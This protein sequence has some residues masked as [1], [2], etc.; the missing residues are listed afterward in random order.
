MESPVRLSPHRTEGGIRNQENEGKGMKKRSTLKKIHEIKGLFEVLTQ[1]GSPKAKA[2]LE[3]LTPLN[4]WV[5]PF[6]TDPGPV[7]NLGRFY[8]RARKSDMEECIFLNLVLDKM[9]LLLKYME[10]SSDETLDRNKIKEWS[11]TLEQARSLIII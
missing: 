5:E 11:E 4:Q 9:S 2:C 3:R 7:D 6:E 8:D 10:D 1:F